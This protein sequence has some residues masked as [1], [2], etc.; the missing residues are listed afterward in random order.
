MQKVSISYIVVNGEN[1]A[2]KAPKFAKPS[3]RTY[4]SIFDDILK[5][6]SDRRPSNTDESPLK[7]MSKNLSMGRQPKKEIMVMSQSTGNLSQTGVG[8]G[9][10]PKTVTFQKSAKSEAAMTPGVEGN[11]GC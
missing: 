2:F 11:R 3:T 4:E 10:L 7:R 6:Y 1:A 9:S 5:D 8:G